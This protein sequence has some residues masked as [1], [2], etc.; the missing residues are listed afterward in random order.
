MLADE[1]SSPEQIEIFR[2][3]TG[4]RRLQL[5]EQ[6]YRTARKLK[7]AGASPRSN[8]GASKAFRWK[9]RWRARKIARL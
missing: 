5:A 8:L 6:L 4:E 9:T 7:R 2:P 3:M 1:K